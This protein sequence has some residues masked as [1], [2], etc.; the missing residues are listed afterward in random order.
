MEENGK[1]REKGRSFL[2]NL[3][4][5]NGEMSSPI[6]WIKNNFFFQHVTT[7]KSKKCEN[8]R[9]HFSKKKKS[10]DIFNKNSNIE[11][12]KHNEKTHKE[13]TKQEEEEEVKRKSKE[14]QLLFRGVFLKQ[15]Q[16]DQQDIFQKEFENIDNWQNVF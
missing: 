8:W 14:N 7:R 9:N 6:C 2:E 4:K 11:E 5:E 10:S 1:R 16:G 15:K 13:R 3:A 12:S